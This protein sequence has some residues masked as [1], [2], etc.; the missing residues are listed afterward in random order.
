MSWL[1]NL[2]LFFTRITSD[3]PI[4]CA[5]VAV[6]S[7]KSKRRRRC[8]NTA[9][10][11]TMLL[12][13]HSLDNTSTVSTKSKCN[14]WFGK[15]K[16][17]VFLMVFLNTIA[18]ANYH[19]NNSILLSQT[20]MFQEETGVDK[21]QQQGNREQTVYAH[22][23]E[24]KRDIG[25]SRLP[26]APDILNSIKSTNSSDYSWMG[27]NF[28]PPAGVPVF[29]P[30]QIKDYFQNRNVLF[31]GDSTNRRVYGTMRA[32]INADD[33]DD[34][35]LEALD[36]V[37]RRRL[38]EV[39]A[40]AAS[41]MSNN[42]TSASAAA[43][44]KAANDRTSI[45][46]PRA[47][48][49]LIHKTLPD[50]G[51]DNVVGSTAEKYAIN[52]FDDDYKNSSIDEKMKETK[53]FFDTGLGYCHHNILWDFNDMNNGGEL[54]NAMKADYDLI[55]IN[56]GIW[57]NINQGA[58]RRNATSGL[59]RLPALLDK[60]RD[61]SSKDLQIVFRTPGFADESGKGKG[62]MNLSLDFINYAKEYFYKIRM[63][64]GIDYL[65]PKPNIT[66]VDF[67]S[68]IFKRSFR[69]KRIQG[70]HVAHY[71]VEARLLYAQQL[72]H[73]LIKAELE[74]W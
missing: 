72:M 33:L 15:M 37:H 27:N 21:V 7:S 63:G 5:P 11:A 18:V 2:S 34:V 10:A 64:Q 19:N 35:S 46:G 55:I 54:L 3:R 16:I 74:N 50:Y 24:K 44:F 56:N 47:I 17:S 23:N 29:T 38:D 68:V 69:E 12:S 61:E 71:G 22:A 40:G 70:D 65:E 14:G 53:G 51:C 42:Y 4:P 73:E 20:N 59:G 45:C 28:V 43:K 60:I 32:L 57:E 41:S 48:K 13:V 25:H 26:F 31:L 62:A 39:A 66:L 1:Q 36:K 30:S 67:G 9:R 8:C 52:Q 49:S 6:C 58:C